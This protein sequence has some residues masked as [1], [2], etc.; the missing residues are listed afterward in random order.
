LHG[1]DVTVLK[2]DGATGEVL[3]SQRYLGHGNFHETVL[4][5]ASDAE[6]NAFITG[7]A[8]N[9]SWGDDV[10]IMK[11][12]AEDGE[13]RWLQLIGGPDAMDDRGWSIAVGPDDNPVITGI[14]GRSDGSGNFLTFKLDSANGNLIWDMSLPGAVYNINERAGWLAV[15]DDGD[16]VMANRT[17]SPTTGYDVVLHRYEALDGDPAWSVRYNSTGTRVDNPR[18]MVRDAAG[19]LLIAGVSNGDYMVLKFASSDGE[20]LWSGS[21]NGPSGGYDAANCV[22]EA[23]NG[24]VVVSGFS[25]GSTTSWDVATVGFDPIHGSRVWAERFDAGDS[26][27]DEGAFLASTPLGGVYVVGYGY[28]HATSS[29]LLSLCYQDEA[30][31]VP[32]DAPQ[33]LPLLT[34]YPNP[35]DGEVRMRLTGVPAG[36]AHVDLYDISGRAIVSLAPPEASGGEAV[37]VWNG[38]GRDGKPAGSGVYLVMPRAQVPIA[39]LR[40]TRIRR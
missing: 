16:V 23:S 14:E 8:F 37:F 36:T 35:F 6:G 25:T 31:G 4:A 13:I 7:R 27:A 12:A 33:R 15:C 39:P 2:L 11:F 34:A 24:E 10:L 38:I 9:P 29:D 5:I 20:F 32:M 30:S 18:G 3:W 28:R 1:D 21:Y 40:L 22:V 26:Q 19:D 17:W